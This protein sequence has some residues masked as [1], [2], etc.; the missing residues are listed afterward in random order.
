M[1]LLSGAIPYIPVIQQGNVNFAMSYNIIIY[2]II[3]IIKIFP[4]AELLRKYLLQVYEGKNMS[5][6][7]NGRIATYVVPSGVHVR[8]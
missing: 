1:R 8:T 3:Y 7:Y 2:I 4:T 5:R 6:E